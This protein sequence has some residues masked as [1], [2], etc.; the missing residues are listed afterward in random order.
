MTAFRL[1]W[2]GSL[3]CVLAAA[4]A[5]AAAALGGIYE[6]LN[7]PG[8]ALAQ[9]RAFIDRARRSNA[10]LPWVLGRIEALRQEA[11]P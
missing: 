6:Q 8:E 11:G 2:A 5:A 1:P 10:V 4:L 9:Y 7:Q 3:A